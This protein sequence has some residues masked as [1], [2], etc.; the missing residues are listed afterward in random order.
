MQEKGTA[1]GVAI[2]NSAGGLPTPNFLEGSF[3]GYETLTGRYMTDTIP[4]IT[5]IVFSL[6]SQCSPNIMT[7]KVKLR[8]GPSPV[9]PLKNC[10]SLRECWYSS[11]L[12]S[13]RQEMS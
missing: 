2:L 4:V 1:H 7:I 3:E 12:D 5:S 11:N 8:G 13:T 9:R 6:T 10:I